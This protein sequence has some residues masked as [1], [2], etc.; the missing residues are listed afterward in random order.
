MG[1]LTA[2]GFTPG[3][4]LPHSLD[5]RTKQLLL[6]GLSAASLGGG[7]IFLATLTG[8]L[9]VCFALAGL[10][11]GRLMSEIRYFLLFLLFVF[12]V[13]TLAFDS[14]WTPTISA[15]SVN[16]ALLVCW[17]LLLVVLMGVLLMATTR[18]A[19]IRAALVWFLK[20]IPLIN[21]K[22]A[23]TMVGLVVRFIPVILFQAL[24]ISD[25]QRARCV[26]QR[27]NPLR[28]LTRFTTALLR[29][30]FSSAD[31]LA[32][33]MQAR[34]YHEDRTLPDLFFS[35]RDGLAGLA[36]LLLTVSAF[37][38]AFFNVGSV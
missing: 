9:G 34:C 38:P 31:E 12:G 17:R 2:I 21:E 11:I 23:A 3:H 15:G 20:P 27:K 13:R 10:R 14:G 7:P 32:V 30:V 5:P 4:S 8:V 16:T 28:R 6:M 36:G 19:H 26:Q 24:E 22:T 25:A 18:T 29:R 33:A 35:R 37:L 1:Q